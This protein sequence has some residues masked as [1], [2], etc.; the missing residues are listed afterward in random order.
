MER[1]LHQRPFV[2]GISINYVEKQEG[3]KISQDETIIY[4]YII[5]LCSK[6]FK[7]GEE[8]VRGNEVYEC[9]LYPLRRR[10]TK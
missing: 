4:I 1:I 9:P 3:R 8:G 7:E 5:R 2:V 6:L 10:Y